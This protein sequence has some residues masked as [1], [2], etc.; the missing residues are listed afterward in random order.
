MKVLLLISILSISSFASAR[1]TQLQGTVLLN[2]MTTDVSLSYTLNG[3]SS[4]DNIQIGE[5]EASINGISGDLELS[6]ETQ[7]SD[8]NI[9]IYMN[10]SFKKNQKNLK[11]YL[12]IVMPSNRDEIECDSNV[13][14]M[15]VI[16][17]NFEPYNATVSCLKLD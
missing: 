16:Y 9:S 12:D 13:N 8:R 17:E 10:S 15:I 11:S 1:S 5:I 14:A 4:S 7:N 2:G 6:G 3:S